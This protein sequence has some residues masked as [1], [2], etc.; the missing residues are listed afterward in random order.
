MRRT[1]IT[2][3][4]ATIAL[5]GPTPASASP[6][7]A[8]SRCEHGQWLITNRGESTDPYSIGYDGG[9]NGGMSIEPGATVVVAA[10]YDVVSAR[11]GYDEPH[12][13]TRPAC[14]EPTAISAT[15]SDDVEPEPV[16]AQSAP[17]PTWT[18]AA[19]TTVELA[20]PAWLTAAELELAD[21]HPVH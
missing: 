17:D 4:I 8:Y 15:T 16:V 9:L 18:P 6:H 2:S 21:T 11:W 19:D 1:L 20:A 13:L 7:V 5:L 10:E 12:L 3:T 14:A